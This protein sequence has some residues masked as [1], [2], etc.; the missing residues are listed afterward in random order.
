MSG[1]L[2]GKN[3][4]NYKSRLSLSVEAIK[5]FIS[6]LRPN[7]SVGVITFNHEA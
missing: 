5:M 7:D 3:Y 2:G 1:G 4:S 6:K